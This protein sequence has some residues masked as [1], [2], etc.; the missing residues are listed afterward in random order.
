[1]KNDPFALDKVSKLMICCFFCCFLPVII[2]DVAVSCNVVFLFILVHS[3]MLCQPFCT[4]SSNNTGKNKM[5]PHKNT[6][7]C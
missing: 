2:I 1:M 7:L 4:Y 6:E 5:L 3:S